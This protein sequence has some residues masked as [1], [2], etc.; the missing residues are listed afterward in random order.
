M[1]STL[2]LAGGLA[3]PFSLAMSG[4]GHAYC[5]PFLCYDNLE[6]VSTGSA[7][8]TD[9]GLYDS[10]T[11]GLSQ[12]IYEIDLAL[13]GADLV[14]LEI[15]GNANNM[16]GTVLYT[17]SFF[18]GSGDETFYYPASPPSVSADTRYWIGLFSSAGSTTT[19]SYSSDISG[20]GVANEYWADSTGVYANSLGHGPFQMDLGDGFIIVPEPSTWALTFTG[21][22]G[23]GWCASRRRLALHHENTDRFSVRTRDRVRH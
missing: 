15:L 6:A 23:L 19:W 18:P 1:K 22:I 11:T 10:F 21:F 4:S 8:V 13:V 17:D 5:G 14:T 12:Q 16:P 2:I 20:P 9:T 3:L 7:T